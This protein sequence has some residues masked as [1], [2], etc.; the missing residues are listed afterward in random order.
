[1]KSFEP[2]EWEKLVPGKTSD[3]KPEKEKLETK[4]LNEKRGEKRK[5]YNLKD[6]LSKGKIYNNFR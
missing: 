1:M 3:H 4:I 6:I 2:K 5:V